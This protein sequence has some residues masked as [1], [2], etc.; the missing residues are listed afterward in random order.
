MRKIVI[1]LLGTF[2]LLLFAQPASAG[3]FFHRR[4]CKRSSWSGVPSGAAPA[5]PGVPAPRSNPI[6][7][8]QIDVRD[9]ERRLR[10]IE[11]PPTQPQQPGPAPRVN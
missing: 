5:G 2:L 10:D 3:I 1:G 4:W 6:E 7:Q 8:L 11:N 9:H